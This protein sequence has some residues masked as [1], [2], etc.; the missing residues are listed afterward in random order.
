MIS[1]VQKH[2]LFIGKYFCVY[3]DDWLL[4]Q[5][6]SPVVANLWLT[7]KLPSGGSKKIQAPLGADATA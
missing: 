3:L 2:S 1:V 6:K 4:L 7:A 5:T